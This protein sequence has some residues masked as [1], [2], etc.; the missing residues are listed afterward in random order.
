MLVA[1]GGTETVGL[2]AQ[3]RVDAYERDL[4]VV[5]ARVDPWVQLCVEVR[6][7]DHVFVGASENEG[8]EVVGCVDVN[9]QLRVDVIE[10]VRVDVIE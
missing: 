4:D 7:A 5:S 1:V 6:L 10:Q 8:L 3:V 9:V 2:D